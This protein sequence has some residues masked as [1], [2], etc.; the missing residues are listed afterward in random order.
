MYVAASLNAQL[1]KEVNCEIDFII[2]LASKYL[3]GP[4]CYYFKSLKVGKKICTFF[5]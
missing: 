3:Q 2:K 4:Y 5:D 1:E